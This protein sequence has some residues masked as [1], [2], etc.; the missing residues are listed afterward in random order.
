M[1]NLIYYFS[2]LFLIAVTLGLSAAII[3]KIK[4]D[5]RKDVETTKK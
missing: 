5:R 1:S 3:E 2:I 4:I